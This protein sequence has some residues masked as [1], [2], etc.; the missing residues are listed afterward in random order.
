M[1]EECKG[2]GLKRT[3][4]KPHTR[5]HEAPSRIRVTWLDEQERER[6]EGPSALGDDVSRWVRW[7]ISDLATRSQYHAHP[8]I[9]F[10][11]NGPQVP[12]TGALPALESVHRD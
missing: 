5:R 3:K 1:G 6:P 7:V 11:Q 8:R 4:G 9:P 10:I 12:G 2:G